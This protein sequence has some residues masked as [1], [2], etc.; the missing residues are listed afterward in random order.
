MA[1]RSAVRGARTSIEPSAFGWGVTVAAVLRHSTL[2][3][4]DAVDAVPL[5]ALPALGGRDRL[6][7][8][9]QF[10]AHQALLQFAGVADGACEKTEWAVVQRRGAD[11]RL[12]R[13]AA[14]AATDTPPA[15]TLVQQFAE[16]VGA[17]AIDA[18][19]QSWGRPEAIYC[20][21]DR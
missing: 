17:P 12:V 8:V 5:A 13:L 3:W 7:L 18:L 14:R 20:E 4:R 19:K 2:P 15:L 6:S 1:M 9:A 10:A 16:A 21:I 11:T